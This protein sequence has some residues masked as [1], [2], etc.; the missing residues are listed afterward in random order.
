MNFEC[1]CTSKECFSP[2]PSLLSM[3]P[4]F[5]KVT[6][7]HLVTVIFHNFQ[8]HQKQEHS[9]VLKHWK[10]QLKRGFKM[11]ILFFSLFLFCWCYCFV[12]FVVFVIFVGFC[13]C[14]CCFCCCF[15]SR[16][17]KQ[18][19]QK[20]NKK[21]TKIK[22]NKRMK[23]NNKQQKSNKIKKKTN[24]PNKF[25]WVF[26][27]FGW[28]AKSRPADR[29]HFFACVFLFCVCW[30]AK[31]EIKREREQKREKENGKI[32]KKQK[33]KYRQFGEKKR[34]QAKSAEKRRIGKTSWTLSKKQDWL[35]WLVYPNCWSRKIQINVRI[36]LCQNKATV[37]A[38]N[39]KSL[40]SLFFD[41]GMIFEAS[42]VFL[43]GEKL[44]WSEISSQITKQ[45]QKSVFSYWVENPFSFALTQD[46]HVRQCQ[47]DPIFCLTR[48]VG[49]RDE[50]RACK[51]FKR[52]F[53]K[54]WAWIKKYWATTLLLKPRWII[55]S[56]FL[57]SETAKASQ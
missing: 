39:N 11:H 34:P 1:S 29:S 30:V 26:V 48:Y 17:T 56:D 20:A 31:K 27:F 21:K 18:G 54:S 44:S 50:Y 51:N 4:F 42:R 41:L 3:F 37:F 35:F 47:F 40:F 12:V 16:K 32:T 33:R 5:V 6:E 24:R 57:L 19:C 52:C 46:P 55:F 23:R 7:N 25:D 15:V 14:G 9:T 22:Q 43:L 8:Q 2:D 49:V 28:V 13:C 36:F 45:T 53:T 10:V 38:P